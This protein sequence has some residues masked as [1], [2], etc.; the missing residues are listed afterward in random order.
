MSN[1]FKSLKHTDGFTII[2]VIVVLVI[3]AVIMLAVFLVVPI[4]Q[5]S[6]ANN[7][8]Q[9]NARSTLAAAQQW[10]ANNSGSTA[11]VAANIK[12]I[13]GSFKDVNGTSV[14]PT[15]VANTTTPTPA[16]GNITVVVNAKCTNGSP[17]TSNAITATG[18]NNSY[19]AIVAGLA[20]AT[21]NR[22]YYCINN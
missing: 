15:V 22:A 18:S 16:P 19:F 21:T 1:K 11:P 7:S 10:A 12:D 8:F 3:A 17:S 6:A 4:L 14:D 20:S 9:T 5:R 2:E 13:T